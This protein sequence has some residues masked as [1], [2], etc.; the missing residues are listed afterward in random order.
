MQP[1]NVYNFRARTEKK[2][3]SPLF[4]CL[5]FSFV[6]VALVAYYLASPLARLDKVEVQGTSHLDSDQLREL[7]GLEKGMHYWR[8]S[9]GSCR[10][11]LSANPW[12]AAVNIRRRWPNHLSIR[13][14]ERVGLAVL[15]SEEKN[16]VVAEDRV[17][18]AEN[19]G[20]SLPW[21]TGL[22]LGDLGPGDRVEGRVP[23]LALAWA[24]A[25]APVASQVSEISFAEYPTV[26][27]IYTTDGYKA[28]FNSSAQ[29]GD[30]IG[31]FALL[32][33]ELR[34]AKRKGIID[35]RGLQGRGVFIP[36]P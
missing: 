12:L 8:I 18:L 16:W 24:A 32:L 30:S 1:D 29:P 28:L 2:K 21:L 25:F 36:W 4:A 23:E 10:D 27:S 5:L 20:F 9:L 11:K 34:R 14:E 7:A 15:M 35:F 33:E 26:I 22:T 19:Q 6:I 3:L 31:D 17:I 13:V